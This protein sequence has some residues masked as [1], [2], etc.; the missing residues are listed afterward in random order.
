MRSKKMLI[1]GLLGAGVAL[2]ASTAFAQAQSPWYIGASFGQSQ[3]SDACNTIPSCDDKD[4][5]FR[6][7]G[8]YQINRTFA[9]E[10]GYHD[11]GE[12]SASGQSYKGNAWEL[13]GV[14]SFPVA[15]QFSIY[16]K[17]GFYRGEAK[18]GGTKE[19]N[20]DLTFGAGVQYDF[21]RNLGV[22]GEWQRYGKMGGGALVETDVDVLSAGVVY[23]F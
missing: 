22:R 11:L 7:L 21:S 23:K 9:A 13:V 17:L 15:N 4:T 10:L 2:S 1:A 19:T 3:F 6:V 12:A 8:G 16:G 5:A 18:A 14:G 20:N